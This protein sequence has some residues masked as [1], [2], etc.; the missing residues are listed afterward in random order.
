MRY[1]IQPE[2]TGEPVTSL[3]TCPQ[4][5]QRLLRFDGEGDERRDD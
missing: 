2:E 5:Q 1:T 3:V 4:F